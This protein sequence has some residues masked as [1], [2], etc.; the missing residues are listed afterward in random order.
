MSVETGNET[1]DMPLANTAGTVHELLRFLKVVWYRK[2]TVL[3][4]GV[5]L[6]IIAG[7]YAVTATRYYRSA[8][9][10]LLVKNGIEQRDGALGVN[11]TGQQLMPTHQQLLVSQPVL[12]NAIQYIPQECLTEFSGQ[13][14]ESWHSTLAGKITASTVKSTTVL[15]I[16]Y[17]ST[18]PKI[19]VAIVNAV[20]QSYLQFVA[21]THRGTAAKIIDFMTQEKDEIIQELTQ[22]ENELSNARVASGDFSIDAEL[23]ILHP[24]VQTVVTLNEAFINAKKERLIQQSLV[25]G[26]QRSIARGEDLKQYAMAVEETL[27]KELLLKGLGFNTQNIQARNTLEQ[28]LLADI[29]SLKSLSNDF[30]PAHPRI[31]EIEDRIQTTKQYIEYH[32]G[33]LKSQL[34]ELEANQLGPLLLQMIQQGLDKANQKELILQASLDEARHKAVVHQRDTAHLNMLQQ[35]VLRL[36]R[37]HDALIDQIAGVDLRQGQGEIQATIIK[38]ASASGEIVSPRPSRIIVCWMLATIGIGFGV[39]YVQD[40]IDDRFRTPDELSKRVGHPIIG[41]VRALPEL[42]GDGIRKVSAYQDPVSVFVEAFRTLRTS[43][44]LS[45]GDSSRIGFTSSEPG[46]GKTTVIA[47]LAVVYA[48]SGKKT[49]LVDGDLRRPGLT[50]LLGLKGRPGLSDILSSDAEIREIVSEFLTPTDAPNL[51]VISAGPRRQNPS[52]LLGS[53]RLAQLLAWAETEYDQILIDCPPILVASDAVLVGRIVDGM[54]LVVR[55]EKNRRKLVFR[56]TENLSEMKIPL[57]G[58]VANCVDAE[59]NKGYSFG[60]GEGYGYGYGYGYGEEKDE[61]EESEDSYQDISF[62]SKTM[63][64][65]VDAIKKPPTHPRRAA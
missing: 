17:T 24:L 21:E 38:E 22:K 14:R 63:D 26:I 27:G 20:I 36:R 32:D 28:G 5:V 4:V 12:E 55:P 43:L 2:N 56:A 25:Q 1:Y 11:R 51:D 13:N 7:W 29:A 37:L 9:S 33:R 64:P 30:G 46:D 34:D 16:S 57:L 6:A 52:E 41:M 54:V 45:G 18:N 10:I 62:Q 65:Q 53:D 23:Q 61:D 48:Q 58:I 49:L 59:S 35:N 42:S 50:R 60:E 44:A 15:N 8:A 31:I 3:L 47:N 19:A 39:V 40:I